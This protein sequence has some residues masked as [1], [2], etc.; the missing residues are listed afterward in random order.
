MHVALTSPVRDSTTPS[1]PILEFLLHHCILARALDPSCRVQ[2]GFTVHSPLALKGVI[3]SFPL[4]KHYIPYG[5]QETIS[6]HERLNYRPRLSFNSW[7]S[8]FLFQWIFFNLLGSTAVNISPQIWCNLV[9]IACIP[10]EGIDLNDLA[11][12]IWSLKPNICSSVRGAVRLWKEMERTE[13]QSTSS[14]GRW[15]KSPQR[16]TAWDLNWKFVSFENLW[17][18]IKRLFVIKRKWLANLMD[19]RE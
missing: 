1:L 19:S 11:S 3:S 7:L 5:L 15:D 13:P 9:C 12:R 2:G 18:R 8:W 6:V 4:L 16:K 10:K 17:I 14:I